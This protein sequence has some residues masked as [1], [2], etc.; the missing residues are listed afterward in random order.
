MNKKYHKYTLEQKQFIFDNL[1]KLYTPQLT[2]EFNKKFDTNI[3]KE[4][5]RR[6]KSKHRLHSGL[7]KHRIKKDIGYEYKD[8]NGYTYI[9]IKDDING[10]DNYIPK[11]RYIYE[12]K[13]GKIPKGYAI[14]HLDGNP[15][16]MNIDNLRLVKRGTPGA[17]C[18][19]KM[20]TKDKDLNELAITILEVK[21]KVKEKMK[22][23]V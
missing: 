7:C 16:N 18:M 19:L 23:V 14:F 6:F 8:Q 21:D 22:E 1:T 15:T 4:Q 12:K 2:D 20:K 11:S 3:T 10:K 5:I 13:H 17:L 9:K